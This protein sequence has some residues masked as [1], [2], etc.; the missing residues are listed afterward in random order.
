M[1]QIKSL[2]FI[3]GL[4]V[5]LI[6]LL[7]GCKNKQNEN[8]QLDISQA[9]ETVIDSLLN[10][11]T[12]QLRNQ[13]ENDVLYFKR[14]RLYEKKGRIILASQDMESAVKYEPGIVDYFNYLGDIYF[15][16]NNIKGAIDAYEKSKTLNPSDDYSM[17]KLAR[18]YLIRNE[19]TIAIGFLNEAMNVDKYNPETYAFK[20]L[21]YMQLQDTAR[22]IANLNTS[23][24]IDPDY[25]NSYLDL[26]YLYSMKRDITALLYYEN[27][28][29]IEPENIQVLYNRGKFYQDMDSFDKAIADYEHILEMIPDYKS[30][31]YNLGYIYFLLKKYETAI[32]FFSTAIVKDPYYIQA[33]YGRGLCF[34]NLKNNEM[35]EENFNKVLELDP[36][37]ELARKELTKLGY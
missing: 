35:A 3:F 16:L 5:F 24:D 15:Q 12:E 11:Y 30:A 33:Y 21:Y 2:S 25:F 23:V 4:G 8:V 36:E 9:D 7:P 1:K 31:N 14:A 18:I 17:L 29:R 34:A 26:A 19:P 32:Q 20:A 13:P 10:A 6:V 22:A 27:A 37:D 28:L